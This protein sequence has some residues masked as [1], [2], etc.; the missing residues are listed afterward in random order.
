MVVAEGAG[1]EV[2]ATI[3]VAG[4]DSVA[5]EVEGEGG[6]EDADEVGVDGEVQNHCQNG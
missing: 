5:V 2:V 4:A 6:G 1:Q 3:A